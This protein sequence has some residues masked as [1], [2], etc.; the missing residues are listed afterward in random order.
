M[1]TATVIAFLSVPTFL[2][3]FG[4]AN[5]LIEKKI[6]GE[7]GVFFW[8][9]MSDLAKGVATAITGIALG[10]IAYQL[11]PSSSYLFS[12]SLMDAATQVTPLFLIAAIAT[13]ISN[14]ILFC[15]EIAS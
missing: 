12:M 10:I 4:D 5:H 11:W 9:D 1:A 2:I 8:D 14:F 13:G 15:N 6:K 7:H 3:G